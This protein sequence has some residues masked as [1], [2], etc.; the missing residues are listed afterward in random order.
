MAYNHEYP[1]VD[2]STY[3][4]DWL[5]NKMHEMIA[6]WAQVQQ[7]WKNQQEAFDSLK[8]FVNDYFDNLDV[9]NEINNKLDEMAEDGSLS[10]LIQP[11]FDTY[12][13]QIDNT[14]STQNSQIT[15]LTNRVNEITSLPSGSTSGDAELADI[16]VGWNGTT[17]PNAG[18]AVR[19]TT[20]TANTSHIGILF[21]EVVIDTITQKVTIPANSWV[22][23]KY[24]Q[25]LLT[26]EVV[27]DTVPTSQTTLNAIL[28][29]VT[30]KTFMC[31]NGRTLNV[32][33]DRLIL[34]YF[35]TGTLFVYG[36]DKYIINGVQGG[37]SNLYKLSGWAIFYP[38]FVEFDSIN[39]T[40]SISAGWLSNGNLQY[41]FSPVTL[42]M[43]PTSSTTLNAILFNPYNNTFVCVNGRNLS[44]YRGYLICA[45]FNSATQSVVGI[46][47][48]SWN[49]SLHAV[50]TNYEYYGMKIGQRNNTRLELPF[51]VNYDAS[52]TL[53]DIVWYKN[54]SILL[55]IN[56]YGFYIVSKTG[57]V[58]NQ[59]PFSINHGNILSY[60]STNDIIY[61]AYDGNIEFIRIDNNSASIFNT[62][63]YIDIIDTEYIGGASGYFDYKENIL[64]VFTLPDETHLTK[65]FYKISVNVDTKEVSLIKKIIGLP[66]AN[67]TQGAE[68]FHDILYLETSDTSNPYTPMLIMIDKEGNILNKIPQ[69]N[70]SNVEM[71]GITF[72]TQ[73]NMWCNEYFQFYKI[74]T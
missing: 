35:S 24:L 36:L 66:I 37:G 2:T 9:Q 54:E 27:L 44:T 28:F 51:R 5:I 48:Y 10:A 71:E 70:I 6:E 47:N 31:V 3:N 20:R 12:K 26:S 19:T 59:I 64:Y 65:N 72:D 68:M 67:Y 21:G 42:N 39:M 45:Y 61:H 4:D 33:D 16:R 13:T 30:S 63:S 43:V 25:Y 50:S 15:T 60:D 23:T 73:G 69:T 1:Y 53:N 56:G 57:E 40:V 22:I 17:Y 46:T 49:G 41:N 38:N 62:I 58:L 29:D 18:Q 11:L 8:S 14:V 7:D 52:Y 34:G 74:Y 32:N 55:A